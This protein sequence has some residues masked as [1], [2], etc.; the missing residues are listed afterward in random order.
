MILSRLFDSTTALNSLLLSS[1]GI[2][3]VEVSSSFS[4]S[5]DLRFVCV[6]VRLYGPFNI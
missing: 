2:D 5:L 6:N 4:E 3:L 1:D